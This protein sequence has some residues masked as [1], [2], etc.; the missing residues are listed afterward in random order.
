MVDD[1]LTI[2]PCGVETIAMNST[3]NTLIELKK[4]KLHTPTENKKSKFHSLHKGKPP[5][6]CPEMKVHGKGL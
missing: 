6:C 3:V 5:K 2:T 1:L 4:L